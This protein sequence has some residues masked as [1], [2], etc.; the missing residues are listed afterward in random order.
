MNAA[1][2]QQAINYQNALRRDLPWIDN[3][4]TSRLEKVG[5]RWIRSSLSR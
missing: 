2:R 4:A 1:S 5:W 3:G